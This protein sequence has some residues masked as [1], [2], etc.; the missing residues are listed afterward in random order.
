MTDSTSVTTG[1]PAG[2]CPFHDIRTIPTDGTPLTPSPT[3]AEWR[4]E[5]AATPLH[6]TDGHDGWIVTRHELARL[7]LEDSRFSQQPGRMPGETQDASGDGPDQQEPALDDDALAAMEVANLL[8]LDSPQHARVRRSILGRFSVRAVRGYEADATAIVARQ[9]EHLRAQGSPADATTHFAQPISAAV[10]S[11]V[12]GIPQS[13]TDQFSR[14]FV[15]TSTAQQKMTFVREVIAAKRESLGD[16]V[17]SELIRSELTDVEIAGVTFV[18]FTSGRDSVAY[19]IATTTVALL[20]HPEQLNALRD[21]PTLIIGAV[22]EFMR[23]GAM[24]I[25]LFSRTATEDVDFGDVQIKMGESVSVSPVA[26]NRDERRFEN[27]DEFDISRDAYGHLGFGHGLHGCVGQ[28]LARLEI[29]QAITQLLAGLP[30]LRLVEA[31]QE[32]PM[33]F[34]HPVATYEAGSVVVAWDSRG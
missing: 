4:A 26:S 34:A 17:I 28:Q 1:Q 11:H 7:V 15:G 22:E 24:F 29:R 16:D 33:P 32:H 31:E 9:L 23:Y 19:M 14:L 12:L 20:S 25:T 13:H 30:G 18:L 3:L 10:H 5:G 6:Y 21:D 2:G 27:P 8:G